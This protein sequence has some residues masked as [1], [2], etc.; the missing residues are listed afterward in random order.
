M[1]AYYFT[2]DFY[3][4]VLRQRDPASLSSDNGKWFTFLFDNKTTKYSFLSNNG[5]RNLWN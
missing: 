3:A 5:K 4:F 1:S 2:N